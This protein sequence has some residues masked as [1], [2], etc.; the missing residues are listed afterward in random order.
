YSPVHCASPGTRPDATP[1][2]DLA[3]EKPPTGCT[4]ALVTVTSVFVASPTVTLDGSSTGVPQEMPGTSGK[5]VSSNVTT[6]PTGR[7]CGPSTT[8]P[9]ARTVTV[10]VVAPSWTTPSGTC[11]VHVT[12]NDASSG[13]APAPEPCT[14]LLS[15]NPP[16][17]SV[18][19]LVRATA[20]VEPAPIVISADGSNAG[21][22][23]A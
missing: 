4:A 11:A 14:A 18:A 7:S 3:T 8:V 17:A 6:V 5:T 12:V 22:P 20:V 10:P 13:T 19:V 15:E 9:S 1:T 21:V 2:T 16:T 23:H